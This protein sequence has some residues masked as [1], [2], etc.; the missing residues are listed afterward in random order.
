MKEIES[1]INQYQITG[2]GLL[3]YSTSDKKTFGDKKAMYPINPKSVLLCRKWL[4]CFAVKG[5]KKPDVNSY[6]LKHVVGKF[7]GVYIEHDAFIVAGLM[8]GFTTRK[9]GSLSCY[10]N[11]GLKTVNERL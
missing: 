3:Y 8:G 7:Y 11:M 6:E 5:K 2:E 1:I 9:D 10:F 4:R